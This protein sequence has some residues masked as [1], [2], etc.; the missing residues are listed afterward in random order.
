MNEV[1]RR[2]DEIKAEFS[3]YQTWEDRYKRIIDLGKALP[4]LPEAYRQEKF[5]VKGCQSQV[6]LHAELKDGRV[7]LYADSDAMIVKGLVALLLNAYSNTTP[8]DILS[9]QATFLKELGFDSGLS[10]SRTN[11]LYSM[12]KQILLY[13]TAF[14]A[15]QAR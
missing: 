1:S 3:K 2:Q 8:D 11:G 13:A 9:S 7:Q 4:E 6:W 5:K 15:L 10:P 12:L 14:K